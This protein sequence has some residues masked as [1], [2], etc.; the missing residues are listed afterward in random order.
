MRRVLSIMVALLLSFTLTAPLYDASDAS[1]VPVCCRR[2]GVH[3]CMGTMNG[4]MADSDSTK[5]FSSVPNK[6]PQFPA[7]TP[8][9]QPHSFI[10][11]EADSG[12]VAVYVRPS[13]VPQT[14]ARYRVSFARSR[15][16]RGPP[17]SLL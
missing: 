1:T 8:A 14:E 6:C 16:K 10:P 7:S 12:G 17:V 5:A 13:S 4:M 2:G 11:N 15:Q 9:P 3:Q